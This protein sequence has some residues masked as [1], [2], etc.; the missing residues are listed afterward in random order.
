MAA[1]DRFM[2]RRENIAAL[3]LA[4]KKEFDKDAAGFMRNYIMPLLPKEAKMDVAAKTV[5]EWKTLATN[6][7]T[8]EKPMVE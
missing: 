2:A 3:E 4:L 1:L 7:L 8:G 6:P 5:V